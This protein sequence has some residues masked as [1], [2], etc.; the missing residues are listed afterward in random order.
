MCEPIAEKADTLLVCASFFGYAQAIKRRLEARG[1]RVVHFED[2]PVATNFTKGLLRIAPAMMRS[3]ADRYFRDI[4]INAKAWS[5]KDV[6]VIKG[7]GLSLRAIREMRLLLPNARFTLYFWDSYLNMPSDSCRK[8]DL[9]DRAFSFDPRDTATDHRLTYR[10]LFYVNDTAPPPNQKQ[11]IDV[12]F[13]GT[14][15]GDRHAV[16]R[17]ISQILPKELRFEKFLYLPAP[18]LF[19]VRMLRDPTLVLG[20]KRD[21]IYKPKSKS[22]IDNLVA[23]SRI[24]VDIERP[25]Q[26]GYTIRAIELLCASRKLITTNPEM[27]NA[28]FF[29]PAN[30][31]VVDRY[32]PKISSSFFRQSYVPLRKE[33]LDH[34]GLDRWIAEVL[35]DQR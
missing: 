23:R 28:D 10:P 29:D 7:E 16:L 30:I 33:I 15:H 21:F 35:P 6:L 25:V 14:M 22:E 19:P 34:Y 32:A 2:R 5:I 1:R 12:L 20:Q 11:D 8:V 18:W 27:A 9:F 26:T 31:A 3:K 17:R 4:A 24:V 13:F